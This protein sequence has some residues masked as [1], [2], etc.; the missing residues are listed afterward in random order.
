MKRKELIGPIASIAVAIILFSFSLNQFDLSRKYDN[1]K[2]IK[3]ALIKQQEA[4]ERAILFGDIYN[5]NEKEEGLD[6]KDSPQLFA[7]W[8]HD[9]RTRN[10][11]ET[12]SYPAN[13]KIKELLKARN[14]SSLKELR[15]N[16]TQGALDWI[17]RGPGNISGRTRGLIIHPDDPT[18]S[19]WIVGSVGGG[20]WKTTNAG[21]TW[22]N[23]TPDIPNLATSTIAMAESNH[24]V[25]Y[26][27]TGEGFY[28]VDQIDGTGIWK[29]TDGGATWD[30][31]LSTTDPSEFKNIM[32]IVVDPSNENILLAASGLGFNG[33][34]T[35]SKIQ[36]STDGGLTWKAVYDAGSSNVQ[37]IVAD[38]NNFNTL[39]A[40]INSVGVIKSQ[41]AGDTW[42]N[43][44]SGIGGVGR[45][46]LA[47]S[48]VDPNRLYIS[49]QGGSTGSMFYY[50]TD[51]GDSWTGVEGSKNWLGGQGWY[52]NAIVAHP[53]D[54]NTCFVGGI[55]IW[56]IDLKS[57]G[58]ID[59]TVITDGYG[60]FGGSSKG[61]HV[62]QH[63][64]VVFKTDEANQKYRM[65]VGN[66]GGVSYTDNEGVTFSSPKNGYNTSQFYGVDK[67]NGADEYIGGMQ[68]NSSW[69][70]PAGQSSDS[71]SRWNFRWGGDGYEAAWHYTNPNKII[72]S[73]QYNRLGRSLDG[74]N[75][76]NN[77]VGTI[78]DVG[79]GKAPFF[80]KVAK[81]KQDPDLIFIMGSSGVWRS[82]DFGS[83]WRNV[84]LA[85]GSF[86]GTSTFSQIKISLADPQVVWVGSNVDPTGGLFVSVNS[87]YNFEKTNGYQVRDMGRITGLATHPTDP[88]TAYAT[89]SFAQ[90]PKILRTTDLGQTWEDISGFGTGTESTTG[91]PDVATFHLLVMPFDNNIIWAGTE[92]GIFETTDGGGSWHFLDSDL[93]A[94]AIYD[95]SIV[96]DQVI[97]ATHGRGIWTV[98]LPELSGYEP[99]DVA[100]APILNNVTSSKDGITFDL[101][102]REVY[103]STHLLINGKNVF[104]VFNSQISDTSVTFIYTPDSSGLYEMAVK[105]FDNGRE[106]LTESFWFELFSLNNPQAAFATEFTKE[107]G[108]YFIG[109]DFSVTRYF[110]FQ[111][112]AIHSKHDYDNEKT[113]TYTLT[114]PITIA[115]TNAFISYD[116]IALIEPGEPGSKFGDEA[117]YDYVVVEGSMDGYSWTPLANGYDARWDSDWL[118]LYQ[119]GGF[120]AS[121]FKHHT[122]DLHDTFS[123]G[124]VI[125]IRFRLFAD[126]LVNG[127]GWAIDNLEIQESL[128]AVKDEKNIPLTFNLDQNYPNPFNP[129][130]T[131]RY[132]IPEAS[133]VTIKIYDALGR[134]VQTL[135]NREL[136]GGKHEVVWNA[137]NFASGVYYYTLKSGN[138]S[139]TKK[140]MLL[141]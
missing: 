106:L 26:V 10:G 15:R 91:F 140:L 85:G 90:A 55:N 84:K 8:Q 24:D 104:T 141:K 120:I 114:V 1:P 46:E 36:K 83:N 72:V 69:Q 77:I 98:T 116:D 37:Q 129:S 12:P 121:A 18:A 11:E 137:N 13:Y 61:V 127:W 86:G 128:T 134:E 57:N 29:T 43:A 130:T 48:P 23:L 99:P 40:T 73:S 89:F 67:K 82:A 132:T 27:G 100:L 50:S 4:K 20:V 118:N 94:A 38:P 101:S 53:Y 79:S 30:Q 2:E 133:Q 107:D 111:S 21:N 41:N 113:I 81:S 135:V 126:P 131:I 49:A 76:F 70:S 60:Q 64:F 22:I 97:A 47:V 14:V 105:S 93:P 95:L 136:N 33:G 62:D 71:L 102:L 123:P 88:N 66:D 108:R 124:D 87:G 7:Q 34:A 96:N 45:M 39:Y 115:D 125:L 117:F 63:N 74:G 59:L 5:P 122:I 92:I 119:N 56:R 139:A 68:D 44:S 65:L 112:D 75:T 9:I 3:L 35:S 110:G 16:S 52:D 138:K 42:R 17:E 25:I 103:D 58:D 109:S 54:L 78:T 19:T 32:R 51:A 31:L 28:N 80:T 6:K